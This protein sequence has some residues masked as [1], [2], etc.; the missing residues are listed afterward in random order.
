MWGSNGTGAGG[1]RSLLTCISL[2]LFFLFS[3]LLSGR[4]CGYPGSACRQLVFLD[5]IALVARGMKQKGKS[6]GT[7]G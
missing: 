6:I 2:S 4:Q 1:R 3:L 7:V 5:D